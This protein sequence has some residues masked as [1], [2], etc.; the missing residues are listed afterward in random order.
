LEH[1]QHFNQEESNLPNDRFFRQPLHSSLN[2]DLSMENE[3]QPDIM[4]LV[5]LQGNNDNDKSEKNTT[6]SRLGNSVKNLRGTPSIASNILNRTTKID[7][8]QLTPRIQY[9][10]QGPSSNEC[11]SSK[12]H[13]FRDNS[14][15]MNIIE[16]NNSFNSK[17]RTKAMKPNFE[18]NLN[19]SNIDN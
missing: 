13:L 16:D 1:L 7:Q 3:P 11:G 6:L 4:N 18:Y 19:S 17:K 2:D 14:N 5:E 15:G 12:V 10:Y 9:E 8:G